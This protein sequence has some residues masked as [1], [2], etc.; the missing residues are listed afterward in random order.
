M[1]QD[2]CRKLPTCL[3]RHSALCRWQAK[4]ELW[5]EVSIHL[6]A[7]KREKLTTNSKGTIVVEQDGE[8]LCVRSRASSD[9]GY[10]GKSHI[11]NV[12][13]NTEQV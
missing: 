9:E 2:W 3:G 8:G 4:P 13:W 1:F 7:R 12:G 10:G 6:L 11:D 5:Y